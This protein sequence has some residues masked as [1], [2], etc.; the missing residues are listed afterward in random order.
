MRISDRRIRSTTE[1]VSVQH[2]K[3]EPFE[4][5]SFRM[6][7]AYRV[8]DGLA[9]SFE[10]GDFT[11]GIDGSAKNDLLEQVSGE[12]LRTREREKQSSGMDVLKS[13]KVKKFIS[14]GSGGDIIS[15][16]RQGRRVQDHEVETCIAF[17]K[18]GESIGLQELALRRGEAVQRQVLL[19]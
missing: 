4:I 16:V 12:M 18:I 14:T 15:F 13:M 9:E 1:A 10:N 2:S 6:V 17:L 3:N 5:F 11:S 8:I 19:R 7:K